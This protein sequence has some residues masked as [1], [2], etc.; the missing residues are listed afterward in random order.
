MLDGPGVKLAQ[1]EQLGT[2][3]I[4]A[5]VHKERRLAAA[6]QGKFPE[7]QDMRVHHEF[8]KLFFVIFH[9]LLPLSPFSYL[10]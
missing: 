10:Q 7:L 4:G 1:L 3:F 9:N 5:R 6:L 8:Y 2:V